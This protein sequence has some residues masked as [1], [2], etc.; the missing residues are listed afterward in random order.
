MLR[1]NGRYFE[2]AHPYRLPPDE[3][4]E[5]CVRMLRAPADVAPAFRAQQLRFRPLRDIARIERSIEVRAR[6]KK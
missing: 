3:E 1:W 5:L 6:N 2:V 4:L